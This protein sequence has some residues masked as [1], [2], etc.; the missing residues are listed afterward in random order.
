MNF[1]IFWLNSVAFIFF[2]FIYTV[3]FLYANNFFFQVWASRWRGQTDVIFSTQ[4]IGGQHILVKK[5]K[6]SV[7]VLMNFTWSRT[8]GCFFTKNLFYLHIAEFI[9]YIYIYMF[10]YLTLLW[11]ADL[12]NGKQIE[13]QNRQQT[14]LTPLSITLFYG[15][16]ALQEMHYCVGCRL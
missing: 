11:S 5:C 6:F 12:A 14:R 15:N 10:R 13:G 4:G 9:T 1:T 16:A 3:L 8:L 2:Y 7:G